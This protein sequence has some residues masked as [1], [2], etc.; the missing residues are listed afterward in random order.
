[1]TGTWGDGGVGS[2]ILTQTG[3]SISG[4]V[5]VPPTAG[6]SIGTNSISG[7]ISGNAVAMTWTLVLIARAEE[8]TITTTGSSVFSLMA[9]SNTAMSGQVSTTATAVCSGSQQFCPPPTTTA[10]TSSVSMVKQ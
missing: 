7:S 2:I 1:V 3:S 5:L 8:I 4:T 9:T 10:S 6:V